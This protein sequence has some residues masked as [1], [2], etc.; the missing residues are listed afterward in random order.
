MGFFSPKQSKAPE[1]RIIKQSSGS[2]VLDFTEFMDEQ[3]SKRIKNG[4]LD[5]MDKV[6][7]FE[8]FYIPKRE[9]EGWLLIKGNYKSS[10]SDER[11]N[12]TWQIGDQTLVGSY[13]DLEFTVTE[14]IK[15]AK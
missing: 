5:W 7:I 4:S 9:A 15:K 14:R 12:V 13:N 6:S 2:R 8:S 10:N 3:M 1:I 11:F